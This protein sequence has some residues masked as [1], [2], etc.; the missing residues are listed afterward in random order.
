MAST[1]E[2]EVSGLFHNGQAAVPLHITLKELDFPQPPTP[3]KSDNSATEGIVTATV[4]QK[5]PNEMYMR[6]YWMMDRVKQKD[7]FVNLKRVIQNMVDYFTKHQPPH[8][9]K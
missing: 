1:Y 9:H 7:F 3:N 6:F 2:S 4:R 5:R 8:H